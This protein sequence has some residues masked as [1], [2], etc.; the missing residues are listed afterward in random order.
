MATPPVRYSQLRWIYTLVN[1]AG[2][3]GGLVL[4]GLGCVAVGAQLK[5]LMIV[6]GALLLLMAIMLLTVMP[7][8]LRMEATFARQLSELRELRQGLA[9][10][11]DHLIVIAENTGLSD[12]AKS[13]SP[14]TAGTRRPDRGDSRRNPP[15]RLGIVNQSRAG[16]GA[17]LRCKRAGRC[18]S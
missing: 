10:Q 8:L 15:G 6:A 17:P 11:T 16:V 13:L 14:P 9:K 7:L 5:T 2:F 1:L 12:A 4:I 18:H 3:V